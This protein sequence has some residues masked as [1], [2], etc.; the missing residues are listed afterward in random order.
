MNSDVAQ[1]RASP[2]WMRRWLIDTGVLQHLPG[3][4]DGAADRPDLVEFACP[5]N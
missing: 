3:R 1:N 4:G 2:A 5:I